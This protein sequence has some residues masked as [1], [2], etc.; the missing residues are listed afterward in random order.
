[1]DLIF[2]NDDKPRN[3]SMGQIHGVALQLIGSGIINLVVVDQTKIRTNKLMSG[4]I[5]AKVTVTDV[6]R[7]NRTYSTP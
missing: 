7:N 2:H 1:M 3:K 5:S 6:Q 4:N